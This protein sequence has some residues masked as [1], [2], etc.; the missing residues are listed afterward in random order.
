MKPL[1]SVI[2]PTFNRSRF[3]KEAIDSALAQTYSHIE[4]IVIDDGSTD[5]TKEIVKSFG[6]KVRYVYQNHSELPATRNKGLGL[7]KGKYVAFLDDDDVWFSQKIEKEVA[8]LESHPNLGFIFSAAH[9]VDENGQKIESRALEN[10]TPLTFKNLYNWNMI[11]SPSVTL[12]RKECFDHVGMFD[13]DLIQSCD[14]DMWLRIAQEYKFDYLE[15]YLTNYRMHSKSLSKDLDRRA[16]FHKMI[17]LKADIG[18]NKTW[19]QTR[20]RIARSYYFIA[21]QH[22]HNKDSMKAFRKFIEAII[23]WPLIGAYFWPQETQRLRFTLLYRIMKVYGLILWCPLRQI[24]LKNESSSK[25][26]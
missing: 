19:R 6:K 17:F 9:I 26:F 16:T 11:I 12:I 25:F 24:F 1:V 15:A 3:F 8:Y 18:R 4:I 2:I 20:I 13:E 21:E 14:Y 7:A 10:T 5:N 22:Y 23:F